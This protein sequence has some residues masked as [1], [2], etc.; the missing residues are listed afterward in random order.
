MDG[1]IPCDLASGVSTR[2]DVVYGA[3]VAAVEAEAGATMEHVTVRRV[4]G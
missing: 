4:G 3:D 1:S 2:T